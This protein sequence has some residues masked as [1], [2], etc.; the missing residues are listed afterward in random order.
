MISYP[1]SKSKKLL[2]GILMP[3]FL[4]GWIAP[5]TVRAEAS[6]D[7]IFSIKNEIPAVAISE[8]YGIN[9]EKVFAD[10]SDSAL[11]NIY[12]THASQDILDA[13]RLDRDLENPQIDMEIKGSVIETDDTYF[14]LDPTE[15]SKQWYL[16]KTQIPAA[17][18]HTTGTSAVTV[19]IIDTGIHGKHVELNDGRV[20]AGYNVLTKQ[21]ISAHDNSDDNGHG[22][23]VA[24]I[25]GAI[26]D[27]NRG[28]AGINWKVKLMPV[29]ALGAQG[30]GSS[31]NV[32]RG[33]VWAAD[34]GANI[35]NLSLGGAG[36]GTNEALLSAITYAYGKGALIVAAAGN[37]LADEGL[38]LDAT[39]IYPICA[40]NIFNMVLGVA[41]TDIN[42][43]KA[44]F[45]NYGSK[46]IDISA[47]G[48]KI[49]TTTFLPSN[50]SDNLLIF[51]SGTS[52]ATPIVSGIAALY[53]AYNPNLSNVEIRNILI[54]NADN[55]DEFNKTACAGGSCKGLLGSGRVNAF[56]Y[57]RQKPVNEGSLVRN[58]ITR[59]V[60]IIQGEVKRKISDFVFIQRGY[61]A[62]V[63]IEDNEKNLAKYRVGK[64]FPPIDGTLIK[65]TDDATVYI[66]DGGYA[67][68]VSRSVFISR[69]FK[70]EN[71]NILP[72][73]EVSEYDYTYPYPHA[74][75]TLL[76]ITDNPL[77]YI[78]LK[79]VRRPISYFTFINRRL[80]FAK[81][82]NVSP[83]ELRSIQAPFDNYW[84]PPLDGTLV[85]STTDPGIYVIEDGKKRLL[86]YQTFV[87]RRYSF[88]NVKSLPQ[89]EINLI[90][91]G[92]IIN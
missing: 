45:S 13:M 34:N 10:S 40:D 7:I 18:E 26:A 74:E 3:I 32:S 43:K 77:I 38:S 12:L 92:T 88:S 90:E 75:G 41:A 8:R 33:I 47:P 60:F 66:F 64:P 25:L 56:N 16:Q 82:I 65:G 50:P 59:E 6:L 58:T 72:D 31:S 2:I 69:G 51:G 30:S 1:A 61:L 73:D 68:A 55:I 62:S 87:A 11:S 27:N 76:G 78:I 84:A 44:N 80:S 21:S 71:I 37:D 89:E 91:P 42:D 29:K 54:Q 81:V 85:K 53:K 5:G 63:I 39:T 35:I 15:S 4:L 83:E 17:W 28:I 9:L 86:S 24:G 14:T 57:F 79:Q 19:A 36:F 70:F 23:A 20:I 22:T 52:V 46:C 67:R 49:V 48:K